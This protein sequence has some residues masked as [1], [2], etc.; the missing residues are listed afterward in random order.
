M[1]FTEPLEAAVVAV[2]QRAELAMPNRT[3]LPSMFPPDWSALRLMVDPE[4]RERR[5]P[6]APPRRTPPAGRRT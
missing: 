1:E 2:A 6:A 5:C 3:S 4:P